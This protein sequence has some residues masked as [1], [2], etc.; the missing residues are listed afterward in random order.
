MTGE[1]LTPQHL[2]SQA[3][4]Q[5]LKSLLRQARD[6]LATGYVAH[7]ACT[8][9]PCVTDTTTALTYLRQAILIVRHL[10]QGLESQGATPR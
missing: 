1:T 10:E 9:A 2:V 5:E 7:Q 8:C 6:V 4:V 3:Q